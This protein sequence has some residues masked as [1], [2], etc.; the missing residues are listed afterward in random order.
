MISFKTDIQM[1]P[2]IGMYKKSYVNQSLIHIPH[3][4][5]WNT[6]SPEAN[7]FVSKHMP[8]VFKY[9]VTPSAGI[10]IYNAYNDIFPFGFFL[11]APNQK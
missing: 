3:E 8:V 11:G 4:A 10:R 7:H 1:F 9:R 2:L 6:K 5:T